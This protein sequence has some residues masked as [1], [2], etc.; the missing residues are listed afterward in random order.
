MVSFKKTKKRLKNEG[1][2]K[3]TE[4]TRVKNSYFGFHLEEDHSLG[5]AHF[6]VKAGNAL[7]RKLYP[8][9]CSAK[10]IQFSFQVQNTNSSFTTYAQIRNDQFVNNF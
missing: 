3:A 6:S 10:F 1:D 4:N 7:S 2:R 9:F 5:T 8:G